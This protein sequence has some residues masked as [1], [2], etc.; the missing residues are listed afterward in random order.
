MK[1]YVIEGADYRNERRVY[2][3][4]ETFIRALANS[5]SNAT[6]HIYEFV[7]TTTLGQYKNS[8]VTQ[9]DRERAFATIMDDDCLAADLMEFKNLLNFKE[10][11][12]EV[13]K[14]RGDRDWDFINWLR[15]LEL[16]LANV[17]TSA[18]FKK[19]ISSSGDSLLIKL[20]PSLEL[21]KLIL[22]YHNFTTKKIENH[23]N[24]LIKRKLYYARENINDV[25]AALETDRDNRIAILTQ[26]KK[27]SA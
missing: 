5:P 8:V 6:L 7:E 26:A 10:V 15:T 13:Q 14:R 2:Y 12:D 23:F 16:K 17:H 25:V 24:N 3:S 18:D 27:E 20:Q 21:Y 9:T 11:L 4:E 22:K 19:F 1:L